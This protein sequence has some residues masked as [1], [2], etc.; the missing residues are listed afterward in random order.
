LLEH[1]IIELQSQAEP[2]GILRGQTVWDWRMDPR[3]RFHVFV[4]FNN[5]L[6]AIASVRLAERIIRAIDD[7]DVEQIDIAT[8]LDRLREVARLG[9]ELASR[10]PQSANPS[11]AGR[12]EPILVTTLPENVPVPA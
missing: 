5:E 11:W 3:G 10:L 8:E 2:G 12:A 9:R 6:L 7:N 4:D 1:L